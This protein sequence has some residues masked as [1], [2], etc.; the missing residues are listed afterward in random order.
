[1]TTTKRKDLSAKA[2]EKAMGLLI[3]TFC[4]IQ[5]LIAAIR[6]KFHGD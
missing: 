3:T 6:V 4:D 2:K 5:L 1:M